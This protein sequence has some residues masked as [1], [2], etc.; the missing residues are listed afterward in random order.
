MSRRRARRAA[1]P[2][3]TRS[4]RALPEWIWIGLAPAALIALIW[5]SRGAPLGTPVADDFAF[6]DRLAFH[7]PLDPFDSMGATYYWRPL[8]RQAGFSLVG[9]WL[10][11]S[12]WAAAMFHAVILLA[13]FAVVY[14]AARRGFAPPV[15]AAIA[16]FPLLAEP[17]RA[18]LTWPSGIQH[19]LAS[20]FVA[21]AIHEALAGRMVTAAAASLA[22]VLSHE[23]AALALPALPLIAW[24]R[25]HRPREAL[26]WAGAAAA[27]GA[28]WAVGYAVALRHGVQLPPG[29][30]HALAEWHLPAV[31]TRVVAAS[32]N[33]EDQ[34][35]P[36]AVV[37]VVCHAVLAGFAMLVFV[38]R[39]NR[40]EWR[41]RMVVPVFAA[42]GFVLGILPLALLPDWNSWRAWVPSLA[43]GAALTSFFGRCSPWLA[44]GFVV[45]RLV[46]LLLAPVAPQRVDYAPPVTTSDMSFQRLARLQ[47][48]VLSTRRALLEC[49]PVLP[50]AASARFWNAPRMAGVGFMDSLAIRVWYRDSTIQWRSFGGASGIT[51]HVDVLVGF[52]DGEAWPASAAGPDAVKHYQRACLA[53]PNEPV[54]AESLFLLA[55]HEGPSKRGPFA[56]WTATNL[57]ILAVTRGDVERADSLVRRAFELGGESADAWAIVAEIAVRRGDTSAA[58]SAVQ[59]CLAMDPGHPGARAF[60]EALPR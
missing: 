3:P 15:A 31:L 33:L 16:L 28:L 32:L 7:R 52:V 23:S 19:L 18:L 47:R 9:S 10:L 49:V 35:R 42:A 20:F 1:D 21:A 5:A 45:L 50:P 14:S 13:L 11:T 44:G 55:A 29:G 38:R 27:I 39:R 2:T 36:Q 54:E 59:R 53:M 41:Q 56:A 17:A 8:S 24:L 34:A 12:P 43:L 22:G 4:S 46:A 30:L 57:A 40:T 58:R 60:L 51:Q 26:R 37:L 48:T 25:T 6:L